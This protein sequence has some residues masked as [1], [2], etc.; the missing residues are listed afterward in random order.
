MSAYQLNEICPACRASYWTWNGKCT[1]KLK[2]KKCLKDRSAEVAQGRTDKRSTEFYAGKRPS[3]RYWSK[4][5]HRYLKV[6][7]KNVT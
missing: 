5:L 7:E 1:G 2:R 4:K 3:G 6:D